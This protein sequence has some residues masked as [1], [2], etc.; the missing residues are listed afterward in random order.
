LHWLSIILWFHPLSWRIRAAHAA[1]CE[2]VSDATAAAHLGDADAYSR[3]LARIALQV[4]AA[5][6]AVSAPLSAGGIP[7][8]RVSDIT[9]RLNLLKNKLHFAPLRRRQVAVF[10]ALGLLTIAGLGSMKIAYAQ[11]QEQKIV[12]VDNAKTQQLEHQQLFSLE[13]AEAADIAKVLEW[14]YGSI[15]GRRPIKRD[16]ELEFGDLKVFVRKINANDFADNNDDSITLI[17]QQTS[18]GEAKELIVAE[19]NSVDFGGYT[20]SVADVRP[21]LGRIGY[22]FGMVGAV[23]EEDYKKPAFAVKVLEGVNAL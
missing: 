11:E 12:T 17:A 23:L 10:L 1:A 4:A 3:T 9:R 16:D 18:T 6:L 19:D 7:F 22:G 5:P 15:P 2:E 13:R 14:R 8:A 21:V 20:I